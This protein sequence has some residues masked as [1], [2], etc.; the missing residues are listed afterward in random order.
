MLPNSRCQAATIAALKRARTL[1][2]LVA[3]GI[4]FAMAQ[5]AALNP[6]ISL[7][8]WMEWNSSLG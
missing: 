4:T 7:Y 6:P 8:N 1:A 3:L 2:V 5:A